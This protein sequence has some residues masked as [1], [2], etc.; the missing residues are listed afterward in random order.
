MCHLSI[1]IDDVHLNHVIKNGRPTY[2]VKFIPMPLTQKVGGG[3]G[4]LHIIAKK[5]CF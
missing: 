3:R 2:I 5:M 4:E 1:L